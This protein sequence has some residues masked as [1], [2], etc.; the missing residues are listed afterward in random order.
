MTGAGGGACERVNR[1]WSNRGHEHKTV[2]RG[3][4]DRLVRSRRS[5]DRRRGREHTHRNPRG[6]SNFFVHAYIFLALILSYFRSK[7]PVTHTDSWLERHFGSSSSSLRQ[8]SVLT[9]IQNLS[10]IN[11]NIFSLTNPVGLI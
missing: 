11:A 9:L 2:M 5:D 6:F 8:Q 3:A 1:I 7:K 4:E 10:N